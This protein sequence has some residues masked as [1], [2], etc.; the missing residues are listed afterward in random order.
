MVF[1]SKECV[2]TI[3]DSLVGYFYIMLRIVIVMIMIII[4]VKHN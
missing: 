1:N 4:I 3:S 2:D